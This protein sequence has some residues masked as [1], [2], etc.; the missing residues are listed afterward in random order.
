MA[1]NGLPTLHVDPNLLARELDTSLSLAN[2]SPTGPDD[3]ALLRDASKRLGIPLDTARSNPQETKRAVESSAVDLADYARRFPSTA[4]YLANPDNALVSRD[5]LGP[6]SEVEQTLRAAIR[7]SMLAD[8]G[9]GVNAGQAIV[10]K[11]TPGYSA[12][13]ALEREVLRTQGFAAAAKLR[14]EHQLRRE[15]ELA[16]N[17]GFA[18]PIQQPEPT[19]GNILGGLASGTASAFRS[20]ALGLQQQFGDLFDDPDTPEARARTERYN[21]ARAQEDF[22]ASLKRPEF[23][24]WLSDAAYGGFE[25]LAQTLPALTLS[26]G[27]GSP[28][29]GLLAMGTQTYGE[30]YGRYRGRGAERGAASMGA[31]GEA[32]VEVLTEILP[33]KFAVER[34]GKAGLGDFL[35][36]LLAR[37]VPGEQ[38]A[39]LVQDAIDTAIA[40]PDKTWAEYWAERPDAAGRTLIA[41]LVQSGTVAAVGEG[42]GRLAGTLDRKRDEIDEARAAAQHLQQL[43]AA[44]GRSATRQ[45]TPATFSQLV[46]E[47]AEDGGAPTELF[48]DARTLIAALEQEGLSREQ[49]EQALPSVAEQIEIAAALESDIVIPIGEAT[50]ALAG[51]GLE[52]VL[53]QNARTREDALSMAEADALDA[54]LLQQ[55][56]VEAAR[57]MEEQTDK[58]AWENDAREVF[59]TLT[60]ELGNAGRFSPDVNRAYATLLRNFYATTASRLGTAPTE[61]YAR[62]PLQVSSR[63]PGARAN[64]LDQYASSVTTGARPGEL[65]VE[66]VHFSAGRREVLDGSFYGTGARGAE[67]ARLA[68]L[69]ADSPLRRRV[70]AYVD[71]GAG[72]RPE[73]GVGSTA[74][75]VTLQNVYDTGRDPLGIWTGDANTREQAV[76][77]AGFD[78]YYVPG[79]MAAGQGRTQGTVVTLGDAAQAIPTREYAPGGVSAAQE[80]LSPERQALEELYNDNRIPSGVMTPRRLGERVQRMRPDLYEI[81][82]PTGL[83]EGETEAYK[84]DIIAAARD[85]DVFAQSLSTRLPTAVKAAEDPLNA[86]LNITFD[87]ALSDTKT[88]TKNMAALSAT[89]NMRRLTGRGAKDP[90]RQAEAFIEHVKGNLLWLHDHM[91]QEWRERAK[92]WYDGGRKTIDLWSRRYGTSQMQGAAVIA[93]MS[94][95]NGWFAN[96]SQAE[97]VMD[98]VFG[99]RDVRWDDAMTAEAERISG[100][101]GPDANMQAA[102][103]K[104]LGE[105]LD[106]PEVAARWI[107]VYDQTHNNRAYRVL[108]PEGGA[109][110]Y[111]KTGAG[112]DATM[113]WKSYATIAKAVSVLVDGRA[114]NVHYQLGKEHKVRNF[115]NNLLEPHSEL[116][117]ATIDTHA[118][119][120]ALLRPLASSDT[121]VLQAFGGTGAASSSVTG[122]RGTYPIYL[123][124]YRRAAEER[125]IQA[126]EMQ[127]ITWEAVRGLFE[128]AKKAG[129]KKKANAI[130]ERYKS[131]EIEQEQ[132]QQEIL[133]LAGDITPPD[134]TQVPFN[135]QPARTYEGPIQQVIDERGEVGAQENDTTVVFEVAPD[136]NDAELTARWNALDDAERLR[137]SI[138]V[139]QETVPKVLKEFSTDG[140]FSVQLGGYLGATNP[141]LTLRLE[142]PELAV[143]IAKAMGHILSQDSMVVVSPVAIAGTDP[144]GSVTLS[145]PEGMGAAEVAELYDRLWALED[146]GEKLAGG[147]TTADGQMAILNF[148]GLDTAEL[149]R[150]IDEH[151]G[152]AFEV[153]IDEVFAAFPQREDYGYGSDRPEG[154]TA[155]TQSSVQKRIDNIRTEAGQLL[156]VGLAELDRA[157]TQPGQQQEV[158]EV[159]NQSVPQTE[160]VAVQVRELSS[161][162][163][164]SSPD[165]PGLT[166]TFTPPREDLGEAEYWYGTLELWG[167]EPTTRRGVA[168]ELY[169]TALEIIQSNE[170]GHQA[171]NVHSDAAGR[172]YQRLANAGVPYEW[173]PDGV[174]R[175]SADALAQVDLNQVRLNLAAQAEDSPRGGNVGVTPVQT[176]TPAFKRWFGDSKVVDAEGK[177]LVVYHVTTADFSIFENP[178]GLHFVTPSRD[179]SINDIDGST[180]P[181]P[182]GTVI[183]PVYVSA[184]NP[185]DYEN[186]K[187]VDKVAV[188]AGLSRH[189]IS[190]VKKGLWQRIEDRTI[191]AAI[192]SL[193][194]D[195]LYVS[196]N[197]VKNLAVFRPEQIKS[198]I[199]NN[200]NFDPADPNIL[201][202]RS[203]A[204]ATFNPATLEIALLE[205][206]D[207][208]SFLHE[209]GHFFFEMLGTLAAEPNAPQALRDDMQVLLDHIGF[210]GAIEEW[211]KLS[212]NERREGHETIAETFEQYLFTGKAPTAEMQSLFRRFKSWLIAVY[213]SLQDFLDGNERASLTPE[214]R[215]VFDRLIATEEE[216][217]AAQAV[218]EFQPLFEEQGAMPQEEWEAYQLS[219]EQHQAEAL[220]S[221]QSRALRDMKWLDNAKSRKLRELQRE[222]DAR[223]KGLRDE[224]TAEIEAEPVYAAMGFLKHGRLQADGEEIQ[225]AENRA[226][227]LNI[228]AVEA[229]FPEGDLGQ[230]VDW[231]KLGYGKYGM[232]SKDGLPP[233]VVAEM[234]GFKSGR[235]L[236]TSLLNAEPK[237]AAINGLTD[238]RMLERYGDLS[239][240][241]A[242]REAANEALAN[243]ARAR[244]VATEL[245]AVAQLTGSPGVLARAARATAERIVAARKVRNLRPDLAAAAA[246]RARKA[247]ERAMASGDT[248]AAAAAKR[249]EMLNVQLERAE[250]AAQKEHDKALRSFQKINKGTNEKIAK[251][252][253]VDLV[254]A[255]RAVLA[256]Y[257]LAPRGAA[258][259]AQ[260]YME[261]LSTYN[262]AMAEDLR[263]MLQGLP[264]TMD[265]RELT[266]EQFNGMR[267]IVNGLYYLSKRTKQM[268]ID[269]EKVEIDAVADEIVAGVLDHTGGELPPLPGYTNTTTRA[270]EWKVGLLGAKASL[271]RVEAWA[272]AMG[273]PFKKYIW[274]PVSEAITRA[275]VRRNDMVKQYLELLKSIEKGLTYDKIN[276]P[277]LGSAGFTFNKGKTELLHAVLHTGNE[278]NLRKLLLGRGWGTLREDGSLDTS[279]WDAFM[280]RMYSEGTIT[281]ADMDFVQGVWD[282]LETVKTDAQRAHK[283]MYGYYFSEIT[284]NPVQTPWGEYRGGYAPAIA[285]T[286]SSPDAAQKR[287]QEELLH[288][289]NSFMFPTTGKGFTMSRV[290]YNRPL[291][292]DLR[293]IGMH[294]DKVAR[295][296]YIEPAVRD[297]GKLLTN[298][299]VARALNGYDQ[300]LISAMLNP[301]LQ[302][303]A[304]QN[305]NAPGKNPKVDKFFNELRTRSGMV[306]MFGNIVNTLQQFTGFSLAAVKVP[307]HRLLRANARY[308]TNH[309]EVVENARTL[310]PWLADRMDNHSF[311]MMGQIDK[312]L[313]DPNP[314]KHAA[315]YL[316]RNAYFMQQGVQN[317]MDIIVWTGAYDHAVAKGVNQK[318]AVRYAD[319]TVRMTQGSFAPEDVSAFEV[320]SPFVRLFTQFYGY[321][322]MWGNLLGAEGKKALKDA[323]FVKASPR[324][325]F[326][327]FVGMAIPAFVAELIA[328]GPPDEEDDEDGDGLL[329]EW[330]AMFFGAQAKSV[331]AM[332]PV[333][334]QIS[335]LGANYMDDK[336]YN[337]RLNIS[338]AVSLI[339]SAVYGG[340]AALSGELFDEDLTKKEMRSALILTGMAFGVPVG[341]L[342]RAGGYAIDEAEGRKDADNALEYGAGL[343]LGR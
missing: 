297:V 142:H 90:V 334:G 106:T 70:Y 88:L 181:M 1:Q 66:G 250:R 119:A 112:N 179:F 41:T 283:E 143:Q 84:A 45:R 343:L 149:A 266:V 11:L 325:L 75:A 173:G 202:Q 244:M 37:E 103:G 195:G 160:K 333:A 146:N 220:E 298:R 307:A 111:V 271:M 279:R 176:N 74:H 47:A 7:Q 296:A 257:G 97:R 310:S 205:K 96:V 132:A 151:L 158:G 199:G 48:I 228:D 172:I 230:P 175:V 113:M 336:V 83:F 153:A 211:V 65:T 101:G 177:P 324:L 43:L 105:L 291:A 162:F 309:F 139:A 30:A 276:A 108:T 182:E 104:T 115:Y 246:N 203:G 82:E 214:V 295:F 338:P 170:G 22:R 26:L 273:A 54:E 171:E 8:V 251:S 282:L 299:R 137:L 258:V 274:Q 34:F 235:D 107:R 167:P 144:V 71:E 42:A 314:V 10:E 116:G 197:G 330:L 236:V 136:P 204:R 12:E 154:E 261:L 320:Q 318:D 222:A 155:P 232:L 169:V 212:V 63:A 18:T 168:T 159:F 56:E 308:I 341:P 99:A 186:K 91:P 280:S 226:H 239:S 200:G 80:Q 161:G 188:V 76:L 133:E 245:K 128:A 122:L 210:K 51:T 287:E 315:E 248:A 156:E 94:P 24:Y 163:E 321:F 148:T 6:L 221:L 259:N 278:S 234:F 86:V 286:L 13:V 302:R 81:L 147:H 316:R 14:R 218:R 206:A 2:R 78:G 68:E 118:V 285:D 9:V 331:A 219:I 110:D 215:G 196:E 275:K 268:E 40:N 28:V 328:A 19:L 223:R 249:T 231:K 150:R 79:S 100:E 306:L 270:D 114:E 61:L 303:S 208:S 165:L 198:A 300:T 193:G 213:R 241:A 174:P 217:K 288:S 237:A 129:L 164:V 39:T 55:L 319:E 120:A 337:D 152:G 20:Q 109:A 253:D 178:R 98:L 4:H 138:A 35:T 263:S 184:Q 17:T 225:I 233:D 272:D 247:A 335:V 252:R 180:G 15:A 32:A 117:F 267:D 125:G 64:V 44:A 123:E 189:A 72:V 38:I 5:D 102:I 227:K 141:S 93:V 301:W 305:V 134:W 127:S 85:A 140:E 87:V 229:L 216:I 95:Q 124:A 31:S 332:V 224:V 342:M 254:N 194:F 36:G 293:S 243:E 89:P 49:L 317:V 238:Q 60:A 294:L 339:E 255:A 52:A 256:R 312:I 262:G 322:N 57:V 311:E 131:G 121:E 185:F 157:A 59:D 130:W 62:F 260:N 290:E 69:P 207:L 313:L 27:T 135:D 192:K 304:R 73:Q 25:S 289:G 187:H 329:D 209:T 53:A 201:H 145:L 265:F 16:R 50:A 191:I 190:E 183:M 126:R 67:S 33:M 264:P 23:D 240:P 327:W 46:Q 29:P 277:E 3:E 77:G 242:M 92:L 58:Q 281:K 323:G 284:A 269:G 21:R 166:Y 326:L 340:T 292:L